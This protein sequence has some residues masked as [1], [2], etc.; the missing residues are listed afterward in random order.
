[1][2]IENAPW[3]FAPA[4]V[5]VFAIVALTM[6]EIFN[7]TLVPQKWKHRAVFL[8]MAPLVLVLLIAILSITAEMLYLFPDYANLQQ[9]FKQLFDVAYGY[10][11]NLLIMIPM[12]VIYFIILSVSQSKTVQIRHNSSPANSK[13]G[14]S[15]TDDQTQAKLKREWEEDEQISSRL[16]SDEAEG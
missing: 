9:G 8:G 13:A 3:L 4:L 6:L 1:M 5:Y 14:S 16:A 15:S 2:N 10:N 7:R 11:S 12:G